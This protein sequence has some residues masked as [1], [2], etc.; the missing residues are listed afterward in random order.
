MQRVSAVM[1]LSIHFSSGSEEQLHIISVATLRRIM[2]SLR[3]V[4]VLNIH[5]GAGGEE[6]LDDLCFPRE[7]KELSGNLVLIHLGSRGEEQL[8]HLDLASHHR[9][10][11][12]LKPSF[13]FGIHLGAS[14]DEDSDDLDVAS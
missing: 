14:G 1:V 5:P 8:H 4:L 11:Q 2:N 13:I 9:V 6:Q 10:V 3:T 12:S 7:M